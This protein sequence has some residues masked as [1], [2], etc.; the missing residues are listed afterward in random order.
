M[1]VVDALF[2]GVIIP[3]DGPVRALRIVLVLPDRQG[4]LVVGSAAA[5]GCSANP[6]VQRMVAVCARGGER[7][8]AGRRSHV[9]TG[10]PSIAI[11][12]L[13]LSSEG[14]LAK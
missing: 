9:G 5:A 12:K 7:V 14:E 4:A 3:L 2:D 1:P 6:A 10:K 11:M 13:S 8:D